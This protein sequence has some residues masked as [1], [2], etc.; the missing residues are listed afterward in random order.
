MLPSPGATIKTEA[1]IHVLRLRR[2]TQNVPATQADGSV[3]TGATTSYLV[4]GSGPQPSIGTLTRNQTDTRADETEANA[5]LIDDAM[6]QNRGFWQAAEIPTSRPVNLLPLVLST[7]SDIELADCDDDSDV[8][9]IEEVQNS[10]SE[11]EERKEEHKSSRAET[12]SSSSSQEKTENTRIRRVRRDRLR[13][14]DASSSVVADNDEAAKEAHEANQEKIK[15]ADK[16]RKAWD[17][18][19]K[20]AKAAAAFAFVAGLAFLTPLGKLILGDALSL[21]KGGSSEGTT[22][23]NTAAPVNV[24][25]TISIPTAQNPSVP[26]PVSTALSTASFPSI[27][28]MTTPVYSY[29]QYRVRSAP[30]DGSDTSFWAFKLTK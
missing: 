26:A 5:R 21:F 15:E 12:A 29:D 27:R 9:E 19:V 16:L 8:E 22:T 24:N 2:P 1:K 20:L 13:I 28:R 18:K 17:Y 4:H 25:V 7:V 30:F 14:L 10:D 23:N 11:W 6:A 3:Q